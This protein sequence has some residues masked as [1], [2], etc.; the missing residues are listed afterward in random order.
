MGIQSHK[1][2][3]SNFKVSL[4][5]NHLKDIIMYKYNSYNC[6]YLERLAKPL[7]AKLRNTHIHWKD[8]VGKYEKMFIKHC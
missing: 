3:N 4:V 2:I 6:M 1:N 7:R 8:A 5:E